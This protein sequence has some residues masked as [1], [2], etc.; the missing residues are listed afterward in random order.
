[1]R[2]AVGEQT[3]INKFIEEQEARKPKP[4]GEEIMVSILK[5]MVAG[6]C[7]ITASKTDHETKK[8]WIEFTWE[9]EE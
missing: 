8:M 1:M 4:L 6:D 9:W 7:K 5:D 3:D 2:V